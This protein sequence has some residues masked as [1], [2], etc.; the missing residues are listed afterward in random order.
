M[1][2]LIFFSASDAAYADKPDTRRSS[3]GYLLKLYS[4]L[5]N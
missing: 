2:K 1:Y 4:L 5:V 3:K